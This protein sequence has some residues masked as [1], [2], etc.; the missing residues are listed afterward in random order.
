MRFCFFEDSK[1]IFCGE[2]KKF[3]EKMSLQAAYKYS[4]PKNKDRQSGSRNLSQTLALISFAREK[5]LETPGKRVRFSEDCKTYDGLRVHD[6]ILDD[7]VWRCVKHNNLRDLRSVG[8]VFTNRKAKNKHL[9]YVLN[10]L[11]D[12]VGRIQEAKGRAVPVL[13]HGGGRSLNVSAFYLQRLANLTMMV[14]ELNEQFA[15]F[16]SSGSSSSSSRKRASPSASSS[17]S[18]SEEVAEDGEAEGEEEEGHNTHAHYPKRAR[19]GVASADEKQ[20]CT[21]MNE[22]PRRRILTVET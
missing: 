22:R 6:Q 9:A 7:L 4:S 10:L 5:Y 1:Q 2:Y 12:L 21:S 20:R 19:T 11:A 16:V 18:R 17:S 8:L 14:K 13:P 15:A 3:V